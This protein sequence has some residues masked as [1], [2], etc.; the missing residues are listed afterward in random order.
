MEARFTWAIEGRKAMSRRRMAS[1]FP[2]TQ[3]AGSRSEFAL[4]FAAL[5]AI[6]FL[7][8]PASAQSP[9]PNFDHDMSRF[10][11]TG[12]HERT[13][14]ESCH[15]GGRFE[16]TPTD[17]NSCHGGG[18]DAAE[19]AASPNHIPIQT[20]CSDCHTTRFWEPARMDHNSVGDRCEACH[21]GGMASAKPVS[22]IPSSNRCGDCHG[23]IRWTGARFDHDLV[24][25]NCFS[26]HN[27]SIATGKNPSHIPSS[28][29]CELCH[30]TRRWVPATAFDH[31]GITT[32]CVSCHDGT[33]A[34]GKHAGHIPSG[35][36]CELCHATN[37]WIPA[38]FDHNA[39]APGTCNSC[40]NGMIATGT[41]SGH[42]ATTLSCDACHGT[43]NWQPASFDHAG[44]AYPG[45]HRDRL[46][47]TD[48][49]GGNS[50]TVTWS[51]PAYQPDC[52]GCHARDYDPDPDRH[53]PGGVSANRD[54]GG[55]GCHNVRDEDFD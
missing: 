1:E 31:S 13:T 40:H 39:V 26:C 33:T 52:A 20:S 34:P 16:G 10:P 30:A 32:N 43:R 41:P 23:T 4:R 22:H 5:L 21:F 3:R 18:A 46:D 47:C 42:F 54:C 29:S 15:R 48:C 24:S 50:Q 51:A 17:C 14:C 36:D 25:G 37:R 53:R 7:A 44:T 6:A 35:N 27:G 2:G 28:N 8:A 55:S 45:D 11:L 9:R 12:R 49:H 19:T 38:S